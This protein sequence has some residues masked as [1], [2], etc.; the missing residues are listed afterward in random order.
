M[1]GDKIATFIKPHLYNYSRVISRGD[2]QGD[3]YLRTVNSEKL[4]HKN[5]Q[6]DNKNY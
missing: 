4:K 3:Q 1:K 2:D 6:N 5:N